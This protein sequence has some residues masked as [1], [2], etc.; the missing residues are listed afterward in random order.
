VPN[1]DNIV[2]KPIPLEHLDAYFDLLNDESLAVNAGSVPYPAT[3]EWA[4]ERLEQRIQGEKDGTMT[5]R[6][7]YTDGTLVGSSGFFFREHGLEIGYAIHRDHRG[8]GLATIAARLAVQSAREMR[9]KGPISANYF[10]DNPASGRVLEKVG[11]KIIGE[12]MGQSAARDEQTPSWCAQLTDDV[13]LVDLREEDH[14]ILFEFHCDQEALRQAGAGSS[15]KTVEEYSA[16]L[17]KV[18]KAGAVTKVVLLEGEL[19][20]SIAAFDRFGKREISYWIGRKYWGRGIATRAVGAWLQ[21]FE[22]P[23]GG[24]YARVMTDHPASARVLQ[25][26]GFEAECNE[27][28]FSDVRGEDVEETLYV[29][30]L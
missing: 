15:F 16:H 2:Y 8:K 12:Q 25:K 13:A 21:Q 22:I 4:K 1:S 18:H 27:V 10:K 24:L 11:F 3:K 17:E 29:F 9:H 6:G 14:E 28:F 26:N 7:L 20:G 5:D 19:V 30:K 23:E